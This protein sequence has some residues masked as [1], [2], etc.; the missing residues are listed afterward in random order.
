[1]SEHDGRPVGGGS[2]ATPKGKGQLIVILVLGVVLIAGATVG[3]V[4][5]LNHRA[6]VKAA[7][8]AEAREKAEAEREEAEAERQRKAEAEAL[9][10]ATRVHQQCM[11]HFGGLYDSLSEVDARLDVGLN[12]DEYTDAVGDASVVYGRIDLDDVEGLGDSASQCLDAGIALEKA[13]NN[14]SRAATRWND[15]IQD[16][17]CNTDSLNL[18]R[19][20]GVASEEIDKAKEYLDGLDPTDPSY[21]KQT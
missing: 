4:V 5:F 1:M 15:C 7:E 17:D 16:F 11:T 3:T 20:W 12:F 21:N 6:D 9:A 10:L 13:F 8:R 19:E 18:S 14:Y 2:P